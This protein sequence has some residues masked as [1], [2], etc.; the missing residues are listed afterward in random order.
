MIECGSLE[1][2]QARIGARHGERLREADWH[3]IEVL[4]ELRPDRKSVV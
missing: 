3:R 4:R 2:A 1:Y